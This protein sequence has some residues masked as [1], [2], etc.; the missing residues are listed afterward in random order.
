MSYFSAWIIALQPS[1]RL[2]RQDGRPDVFVSRAYQEDSDSDDEPAD[3]LT[4]VHDTIQ[5][6]DGDRI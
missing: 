1:G 6:D 4:L 5:E 3:G 2:L